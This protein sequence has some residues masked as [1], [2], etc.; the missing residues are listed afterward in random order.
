[1]KIIT[2]EIF[3]ILI[4]ILLSLVILISIKASSSFKTKFY[5]NVYETSLSFAKLNSLYTKHFGNIMPAGN[6]NTTK[7]V[8]NE[9]L[10]YQN[11][12]PYLDG[13]SLTVDDE[14][15]VPAITS[16]VVVY[17]GQKEGYGNVVIINNS[18]NVDVWYGNMDN[19]DIKLY[20]Y[21]EKGQYIGSV[22]NKIYM[23]FK[24]NGKKLDYDK[25]I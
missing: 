19:I 14:Y 25:Y 5:K 24:S 6:I 9:T 11:I 1:M 3:K 12:E 8:F 23:V 22:K 21:V 2:K 10:I 16:G 7:P 13:A 18:D 15:L 20:Q 4:T 17:V